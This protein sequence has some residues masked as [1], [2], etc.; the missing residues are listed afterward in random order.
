MHYSLFGWHFT[1]KELRRCS[2][3]LQDLAMDRRPCRRFEADVASKIIFMPSRNF[4]A[5]CPG[6]WVG[7][8]C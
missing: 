3:K 5:L 8:I 1:K 4:S 7:E 2:K 6:T